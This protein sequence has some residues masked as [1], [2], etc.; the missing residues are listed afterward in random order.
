VPSAT[1][2]LRATRCCLLVT[3]LAVALAAPA[4]GQPAEAELRAAAIALAERAV[5]HVGAVGR[6]QALADFNRPDG[7]FV[8]GESYVF[9]HAADGLVVAHGGNPALVGRNMLNARD[10][11]GKRPSESL[12]RIGFTEGAGWFE[13]RWPNPV[14]KLIQQRAAYILKVDDAM[15]CGSGYF[16]R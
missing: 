5:A 6:D 10:P 14:T 4:A 9:C 2:A 16:R 15:V 3:L 7:G 12:N 8:D 1:G 13:F 11:D